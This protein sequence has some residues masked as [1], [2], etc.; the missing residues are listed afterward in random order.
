MNQNEIACCS[1]WR[2]PKTIIALI[3]VLLLGAVIIVSILRDRIVN[4]DNWQISITGQGKVSYQPDTA[5]ISVGVTVDN[6][7]KAED[8]LNQL[9]D[10]MKKIYEAVEKLGV[11]K[12]NI[13]T[14]NY[15]LSPHYAS[16][17]E[18]SDTSDM[19][20]TGYDA[21]Q[22]IVVKARGIKDNNEIVSKI[23]SSASKAGANQING[24]SFESADLNNLK[25]EA[26]IKA[27]TD[28][29]SKAKN[30]AGALG[31]RLGKIVGWWENYLPAE[32]RM[33]YGDAM[34]GYGGG[35][36]APIVP[37]GAYEVIMEVNISY[38][39]D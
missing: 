18:F 9:N 5:N 1:N 27:I 10:K 19:K 33:Y 24:I 29:R 20:I 39:L 34:G 17:A 22:I 7:E 14:Q 35:G 36:G 13:Q 26:R 30:T 16:P 23:I 4:R 12:E 21:N 11:G 25:Q 38:L 32:G 2:N 8:A 3:A 37:S 6:I 31:V 28:A 15:T